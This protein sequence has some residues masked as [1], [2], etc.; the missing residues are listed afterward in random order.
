MGAADIVPG[1]SGGTI[2]FITGI[3]EELI[4]SIRSV[5]LG[6]LKVL[7]QRGIAACWRHINGTFLLSVLAGIGI[8]VVS[9]AR[10]IR[11]CLDHYPILLSSCFLG[12]VCA[13]I[14]FVA[15]QMT[16]WNGRTYI[17]LVVGAAI[18]L[19]ISLVKPVT[20]PDYWWI[21]TLAG[22]IAIC[23]MILPG[24]SGSYMLILMGLYSEVLTAVTELRFALLVSF[25]AGCAV[26][27]LSFSHLLS[28]LLH[29]YH[30]VTLAT[31]VGFL[32]GSLNLLWPWKHTVASVVGRDGHVIPTVQ[33]NVWP[34]HYADITGMDAQLLASIV[35][36]VVG[37][38]FVIGIEKLVHTKR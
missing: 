28:W 32:V 9:L 33:H 38:L 34:W 5:D 11:Y 1:V 15:R 35:L 12:L 17:A 4:D 14:L 36:L 31:L 27:L 8:S 25:A 13:S 7:H 18:A 26:G 37:I 22:A 29:R 23:A 21:F 10:I 19:V 16:G 3:Y 20:L 30:N 6:A 24:V 2:A